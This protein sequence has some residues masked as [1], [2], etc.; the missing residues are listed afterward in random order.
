MDR[1]PGPMVQ[2]GGH[3]RVPGHVPAVSVRDQGAAGQW[4]EA[5]AEAQQASV[6][7]AGFMPPAAGLG[8]YPIGQLR[9]R[10]G[11]LAEAEEALLRAHAIGAHV[12]PALSLLRLAQGRLQVA[13]DGIREAIERPP[14]RPSWDSSP[15]TPLYMRPLLRA[16]VDI[17]LAAGDE[18]TARQALEQLESVAE[19]FGAA[20]L[21]ATAADARGFVHLRT[22]DV[23]E[24]VRSLRD[25]V[26]AWNDLDA[27]Y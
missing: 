12:E 6:E 23:D 20:G 27:P 7:L 9:L 21:K 13:A 16:Q 17:A 11:D 26:V 24:A 4:L 10:R 18:A 1:C 19:T 15:G 5:E 25:A 22:G 2:A 8:L 14:R 3:R